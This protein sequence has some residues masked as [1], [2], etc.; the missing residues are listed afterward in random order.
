M[1]AASVIIWSYTFMCAILKRV[2]ELPTLLQVLSVCLSVHM[3]VCAYF[4]HVCMCVCL[5]VC[6]SLFASVYL[7]VHLSVCLPFIPSHGCLSGWMDDCHSVISFCFY[8]KTIPFLFLPLILLTL[9]KILILNRGLYVADTTLQS[10]S[11]P[12]KRYDHDWRQTT[13][14]KT[15]LARCK[16]KNNP[17]NNR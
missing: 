5:H 16:T 11:G 14:Y 2:R 1:V 6:A 4:L 12:P 9:A 17:R 3:Y 10:T 8:C 13:S 7:S 15:Y